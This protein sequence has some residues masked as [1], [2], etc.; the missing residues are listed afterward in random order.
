MSRRFLTMFLLPVLFTSG[1]ASTEPFEEQIRELTWRNNA[2]EQAA[3]QATV[4]KR[5]AEREVEIARADNKILQEKLALAFD[6]LREAR[7]RMD[8]TLHDRV[9][10]LS[11]SQAGGPALQIS[12][13]GGVVL[14]SG[15]LFG[16]GRHE[17]TNAGK[18]ALQPLVT[19]L[20]KPEYAGYELELAGHTDSDPIKRS[21]SKYRDN[22]DLA[23]LRAN[24]VRLFL[25][26]QGV[27]A[28][29]IYLSSWGPHHPIST[30]SKAPNRR[31]E[32][33]LHPVD[34][35]E[36]AQDTGD[37]TALPASAQRDD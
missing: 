37:E 30:G 36:P 14:E 24:S 31:V 27:S 28:E 15:I 5:L 35:G 33:V 8:E 21:A 4:D 22:H 11:T 26:E 1:C 29:R 23:A 3:E 7:A 20:L 34:S 2:A 17:L 10:E 12:Q 32:L 6:A 13:Y 16:S 25:I 19:T 18:Q 9:T